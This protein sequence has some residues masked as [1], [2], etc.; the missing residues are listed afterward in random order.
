MSRSVLQMLVFSLLQKIN[1]LKVSSQVNWF[2]GFY[3]LK[4]YKLEGFG[5][6]LRR[7]WKIQRKKSWND[8]EQK[9]YFT[10]FQIALLILVL[11]QNFYSEKTKSRLEC[12]DRVEIEERRIESCGETFYF[13]FTL[14]V[15][16]LPRV[17]LQTAIKAILC[18]WFMIKMQLRILKIPRE[19]MPAPHKRTCN[20]S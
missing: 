2:L 9:T 20:L 12:Y 6:T 1:T 17:Y 11:A 13:G 19:I 3:C 7:V 4:V 5:A 15:T 16:L 14:H 10:L 18:A 8:L